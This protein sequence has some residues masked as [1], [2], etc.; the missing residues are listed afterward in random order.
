MA[1]GVTLSTLV[2]QLRSEIGASTNVGQGV[3]NL[4]NLQQ[5]LRRTQEWLYQELDWPHLIV[6]RDKTL[7]AG[8]RYYSFDTDINPH[9]VLGVYAKSSG[10]W[11]ELSSTFE[12]YILN[13][14][15]SDAGATG[16]AASAWRVYE[17]NQFEIWPTP[18]DSTQTVRFRA[19]KNLS[20]LLANE[21]V[22]SLDSTLI[23]LFAAADILARLKSADAELKQKAAQELFISIRRN[24]LKTPTYIVGDNSMAELVD[25]VMAEIG[26]VDQNG[27]LTLSGVTQVLRRTQ[28]T[29][30]NQFDWPFL[31]KEADQTVVTNAAG[32][33]FPAAV[34]P[35]R[36]LNVY[37]K[38]G[39]SWQEIQNGFTTNVYNTSDPASATGAPIVAWRHDGAGGFE[40]WPKPSSTQTLR[41]RYVRALNRFVQNS[42]VC[43]LDKNLVVLSAS[44]ELLAKFK[45]P[46][47]EAKG[48]YAQVLFDS[49]KKSQDTTSSY[50]LDTNTMLELSKSVAYEC[51]L[52]DDS[53][54]KY[55][56]I[57]K[58]ILMRTQTKLY[59]EFNWPFL[60]VEADQNLAANT[61]YY[62]F[63]TNLNPEKILKVH[64]KYSTLW[65]E[66]QNG[67][68]TDVYNYSNSDD[69][70]T[71]QPVS[72]WRRYSTTQYEV[73]PMPSDSTQVLRFRYVKNLLPFLN[74]NDVATLDRDLLVLFATA[75]LAAR[76]KLPDAE[77]KLVQAQAHYRNMRAT[78]QKQNMF[79]LGNGL[80]KSDRGDWVIRVNP[81]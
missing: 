60:I 68:Y 80:P 6:E 38:N 33:S 66:V 19:I 37:V 75:E 70:S 42:D 31:I 32:G 41:F 13:V 79:V 51:V 67:F 76:L 64:C 21:D 74:N 16:A 36:I 12:P 72:L 43:E 24:V 44:A 4:A 5:V 7:I 61:R 81:V 56:P 22:C 48:K 69:N 2:S 15:D 17:T 3:N 55:V 45:S 71:S 40:V 35:R 11:N 30:Y 73:W 18:A 65:Q 39:S 29:L 52:D 50:L 26:N 62:T 49:L 23:V 9:R 28:E 20:P 57:I 10:K 59:N 78:T 54:V 63:P 34:N 14:T 53:S 46:E 25:A 1:I 77:A 47:A 27:A 58:Q 8:E